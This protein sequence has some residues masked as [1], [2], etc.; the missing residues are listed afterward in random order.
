MLLVALESTLHCPATRRLCPV[1]LYLCEVTV[2]GRGDGQSSLDSL[3]HLQWLPPGPQL[4]GQEVAVVKQ[5]HRAS[6][7]LH[8]CMKGQS[9]LALWW[10]SGL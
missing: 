9:W 3:H 10:S 2:V 8:A 4:G 6:V 7:S 5:A 1:H